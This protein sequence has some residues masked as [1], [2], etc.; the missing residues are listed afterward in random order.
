MPKKIGNTSQNIPSFL[1]ILLGILLLVGAASCRANQTQELPA[2]EISTAEPVLTDVP[3]PTAVEDVA[4]L[5][6]PI[7]EK[8]D[9]CLACHTDKQTLV[10]TA[11]P[12]VDLESESSG[13]G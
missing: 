1:I 10:D 8:V 9:E 3:A 11:D 6:D 2:V 4:V 5:A 7:A 13:E 12:V